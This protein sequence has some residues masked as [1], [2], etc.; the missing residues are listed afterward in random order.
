MKKKKTE[1]WM[2]KLTASW[3]FETAPELKLELTGSSSNLDHV[4]G[5]TLR[6]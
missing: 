2:E 4:T 5:D 3:V 6:V 1:E